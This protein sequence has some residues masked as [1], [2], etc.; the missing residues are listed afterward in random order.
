MKFENVSSQKSGRSIVIHF[1]LM[2]IHTDPYVRK[3]RE[4][5]DLIIGLGNTTSHD[6]PLLPAQFNKSDGTLDGSS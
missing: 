5:A 2:N 6:R 3:S 4:E 1:Q